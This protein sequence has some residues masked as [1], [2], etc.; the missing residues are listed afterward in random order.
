MKIADG[1]LAAVAQN[2]KKQY[3]IGDVPAEVGNPGG[4]IGGIVHDQRIDG[5]VVVTQ[6]I[7][8]EKNGQIQPP[9]FWKR[10]VTKHTDQKTDDRSCEHQDIIQGIHAHRKYRILIIYMRCYIV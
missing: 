4:N 8:E 3:K 7:R 6:K 9:A 5:P 2:R 10:D 1:S